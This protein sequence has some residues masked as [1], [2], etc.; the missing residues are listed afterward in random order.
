MSNDKNLM[1]VA[2]I[3]VV[4]S[5]IGLLTSMFAYS[6]YNDWLVGGAGVSYSPNQTTG[7]VNVT[8][9][10]NLVINFSS[11]QIIWGIGSVDANKQNATLDSATSVIAINGN[12]NR[13]D[14]TVDAIPPGF[15]DGVTTPSGFV[16]KNIGNTNANLY[17]RTNNNATQFLPGT[18]PVY[19]YNVTSGATGCAAAN[20]TGPT[21]GTYVDVNT[22]IPGTKVC[23]QFVFSPASSLRIDIKLVVPYDVPTSNTPRTSN[24]IATAELS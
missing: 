11:D 22:T 21:Y 4:V 5:V 7:I 6:N 1:I 14:T 23:N 20:Q 24:M 2:V 8:I 3:A 10:Q 18:N 17:L 9:V 13:S 19:Q 12:W 16:L 15:G